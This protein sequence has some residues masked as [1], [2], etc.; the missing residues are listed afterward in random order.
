MV[1]AGWLLVTLLGR[2]I[3]VVPCVTAAKLWLNRPLL[4]APTHVQELGQLIPLTAVF[5]AQVRRQWGLEQWQ[6]SRPVEAPWQRCPQL[7]LEAA[8][9]TAAA[10]AT[11][12]PQMDP[13][14]GIYA[15]EAAKFFNKAR[16]AG[17]R[18]GDVGAPACRLAW[19]AR[20]PLRPPRWQPRHSSPH[21]RCTA[22]SVQYLTGQVKHTPCGLPVPFHWGAMTHGPNLGEYS[23]GAAAGGPAAPGGWCVFR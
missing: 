19:P 4:S 7:S 5:M 21:T 11:M 1:L 3:E 18:A 16:R 23:A 22:H 2:L 15:A 14:N 20:P 12:R 13:A 10:P 8:C 9:L 17:C 6:L